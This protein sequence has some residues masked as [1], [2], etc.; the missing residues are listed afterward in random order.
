[1]SNYANNEKMKYIDLLKLVEIEVLTITSI[2]V[3][4]YLFIVEL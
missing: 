4:Y 2:I 3:V 1:M